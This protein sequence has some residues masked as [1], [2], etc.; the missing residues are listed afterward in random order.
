MAVAP[1]TRAG[2]TKFRPVRPGSRVALVAPASGFDREEF[3]RG[4]A[5][6]KRLGA[7]TDGRKRA[8][9]TLRSKASSSSGTHRAIESRL[10]KP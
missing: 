7:A 10:K 8:G 1:R 2:L 6:L 9:H 3:D 5:E 4:V